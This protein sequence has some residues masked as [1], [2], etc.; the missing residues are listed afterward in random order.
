[1]H[2]LVTY[3]IPRMGLHT[4]EVQEARDLV[5]ELK[6]SPICPLGNSRRLYELPNRV[7]QTD[8]GLNG[9]LVDSG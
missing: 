8:G 7:R 9:Q 5:G 2:L 4:M 6:L 1:M 3:H